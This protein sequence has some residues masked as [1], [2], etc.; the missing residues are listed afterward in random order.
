[1]WVVTIDQRRYIPAPGAPKPAP[2]RTPAP[3]A[4]PP[5]PPGFSTGLDSIPRPGSP[6][7]APGNTPA[8]EAGPPTPP[9]PTPGS[10][11]RPGP[12]APNPAPGAT[13]AP[14]AGPPIP[15]G[16]GRARPTPPMA[17]EMA[18]PDKAR[19]ARALSFRMT[20]TQRRPFLLTGSSAVLP[21]PAR[22]LTVPR[23]FWQRS[24]QA[25]TGFPTAAEVG[26]ALSQKLLGAGPAADL[27]QG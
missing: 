18:T 8:P 4:S 16:F 9:A 21:F 6:T 25:L 19:T 12:A 15:P 24:A 7:P 3:E 1:M 2:G 23:N 10:R 22:S 27:R 13:P 20:S 11:S 26:V 17:R 5:R 14:D